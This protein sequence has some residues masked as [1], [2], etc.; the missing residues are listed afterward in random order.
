MLYHDRRRL[1]GICGLIALVVSSHTFDL[2][3]TGIPGEQTA[4]KE[5]LKQLGCGFYLWV[6]SMLLVLIGAVLGKT[7]GSRDRVVDGSGDP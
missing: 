2:F 5:M 7:V 3:R 1:A 6:L 4:D